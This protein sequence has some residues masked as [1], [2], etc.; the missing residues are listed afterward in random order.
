MSRMTIT[1][2]NDLLDELM[3]ELKAKSKTGA[4]I[5][6]IKDEIRMKKK[7]KIKA[8]AGKMEFSKSASEL[9]HKDKRLG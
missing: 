2:P 6:A 8:M 3:S 5:E 1:L 4:V 9:R 7:E